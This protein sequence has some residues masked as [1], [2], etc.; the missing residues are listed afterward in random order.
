LV[1]RVASPPTPIEPWSIA[2]ASELYRISSWGEPF[3]YVNDAGHMAV[4]A[5][6]PKDT[7]LDIAA[8]VDELRRRGVELPLLI[9]FQDVLSAQVRRLNEAFAGAIAES[10]Y[11]NEY[12]GVY[13]IRSISCMKSSRRFA[14]PA[15]PTDWVWS[16][17]RR[18]S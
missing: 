4:R 3:F 12:R 5:L 8:I 7:R 16:A 14:R 2:N 1:A 15:G 6:D 11:G 17:A 18:P 9:R 13:P 10:N